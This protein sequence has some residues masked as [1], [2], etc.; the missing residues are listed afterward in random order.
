MR[1]MQ[2]AALT[3]TAD[4]CAYFAITYV[5]V[6]SCATSTLPFFLLGAWESGVDNE[7]PTLRVKTYSLPPCLFCP[8]MKDRQAG[9]CFPRARY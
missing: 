9:L 5:Q 7:P 1:S 6:S 4:D 3:Y 8:E 2:S